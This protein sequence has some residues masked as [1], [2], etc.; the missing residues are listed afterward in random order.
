MYMKNESEPFQN[1]IPSSKC[2]RSQSGQK[3]RRSLDTYTQSNG[4]ATVVIEQILL[5]F[6]LIRHNIVNLHCNSVTHTHVQSQERAL[7]CIRQNVWLSLHSVQL[8]AIVSVHEST[9]VDI[10]PVEIYPVYISPV[11][12]SPVY[13]S[14]VYNSPLG[15]VYIS[16]VYNSPVEKSP[17]DISPVDISPI[18]PLRMDSLSRFRERD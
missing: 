8:V 11:Y 1:V 4:C 2:I 18:T 5:K 15:R 13:F 16:P 14:P 10:S 7:H 9:Q 12:N 3:P 17:V 6:H